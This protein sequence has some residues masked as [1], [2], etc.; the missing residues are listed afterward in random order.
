MRKPIRSTV[1][2]PR[3]PPASAVQYTEA[4]E[5]WARNHPIRGTS[6]G[7]F[8][9]I[10]RE[11]GLKR[12]SFRKHPRTKPQTAFPAAQRTE[13]SEQRT[14]RRLENGMP[15]GSIRTIDHERGRKQHSFRKHPRNMPQRN[16]KMAQHT[17]ASVKPTTQRPT[18]TPTCAWSRARSSRR[19]SPRRAK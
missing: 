12:H 16:L 15:L 8:R 1:P 6:H 14:A 4:S 11:K 9:T 7:S 3:V 5:K 18:A 10:S 2:I 19:A 17:D 13:A